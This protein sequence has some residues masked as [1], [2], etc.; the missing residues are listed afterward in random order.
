MIACPERHLAMAHHAR[1]NL[2]ATIRVIVSD[3]ANLMATQIGQLT[4]LPNWHMRKCE[5]SKGDW[6]CKVSP[7]SLWVS[8]THPW[9]VVKMSFSLQNKSP[10]HHPLPP[11]SPKPLSCLFSPH[12]KIL[13]WHL[14]PTLLWTNILCHFLYSNCLSIFSVFSSSFY[15]NSP[16]NSP[17]LCTPYPIPWPNEPTEGPHLPLRLGPVGNHI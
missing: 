12:Q 13:L 5:T 4:A 9:W 11:P 17:L 10:T 8:L 2:A 6:I 14:L 7:E 3:K 1:C 16:L 15:Y